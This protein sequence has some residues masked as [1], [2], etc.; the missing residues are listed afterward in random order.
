MHPSDTSDQSTR[1]VTKMASE[2][3]NLKLWGPSVCVVVSM[4]NGLQRRGWHKP[5]WSQ[6]KSFFYCYGE[7]HKDPPP[8]DPD[9]VSFT[10]F[11]EIPHPTQ[12]GSPPLTPNDLLY[13]LQPHSV[14]SGP[15]PRRQ[16]KCFIHIYSNANCEKGVKQFILPNATVSSNSDENIQTCYYYSLW[17]GESLLLSNLLQMCS[18]TSRQSR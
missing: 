16:R 12:S 2:G 18:D 10:S 7:Q 11:A 8:R 3:L 14:G 1:C 9:T 13:Q 5:P 6:N 15:L 17:Q 4:L